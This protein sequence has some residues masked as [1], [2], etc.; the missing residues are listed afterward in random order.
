MSAKGTDMSKIKQ[1]MRMMLQLD[2][3]GRLWL[4]LPESGGCSTRECHSRVQI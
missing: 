3:R 4:D 1:M 2:A